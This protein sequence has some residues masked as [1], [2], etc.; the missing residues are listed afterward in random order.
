MSHLP[1]I[2]YDSSSP[3]LRVL[4]AAAAPH[5]ERPLALLLALARSPA[6]LA[7]MSA[8]AK[9]STST[10]LSTSRRGQRSCWPSRRATIA[11]TRKP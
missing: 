6:A 9:R 8:S 7:A 10:A 5:V 3:P 1:P 4:L 2:D 11:P